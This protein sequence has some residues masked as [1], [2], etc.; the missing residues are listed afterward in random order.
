MDPLPN[1]TGERKDPESA[2]R[3][4]ERAEGAVA[5]HG[6]VIGEKA[7]GHGGRRRPAVERASQMSVPGTPPGRRHSTQ[8]RKSRRPARGASALRSS[9][10]GRPRRRPV[11]SGHDNRCEARSVRGG[12]E[13]P[14]RVSQGRRGRRDGPGV[15]GGGPSGVRP[16]GHPRRPHRSP[17]PCT[18]HA[19]ASLVAA[20]GAR[21]PGVSTDSS[22]NFRSSRARFLYWLI[23][24]SQSRHCIWAITVGRRS[25]S[26]SFRPSLSSEPDPQGAGRRTTRV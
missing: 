13:T 23:P 2:Q 19:P 1:V 5:E 22:P 26:G 25:R 9:A 6:E 8:I 4:Q 17:V 10:T 18:T 14:V 15:V 24:G 21:Y 3:I 16:P 12:S 11:P 20:G 7:F